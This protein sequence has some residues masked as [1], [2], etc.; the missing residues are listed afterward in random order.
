[1][2][3][4]VAQQA[5]NILKKEFQNTFEANLPLFL[6]ARSSLDSP[7]DIVKVS[8]DFLWLRKATK[9]PFLATLTSVK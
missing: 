8:A 6:H 3:S 9:L 7:F 2:V 1:M 5:K 4:H